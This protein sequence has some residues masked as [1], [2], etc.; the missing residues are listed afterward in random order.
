MYGGFEVGDSDKRQRFVVCHRFVKLV[1][2]TIMYHHLGKYLRKL[3]T[4]V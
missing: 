4:Q 1:F 2:V 3:P